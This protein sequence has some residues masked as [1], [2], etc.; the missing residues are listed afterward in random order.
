ML[1][2][3]CS[4]MCSKQRDICFLS[5]HSR[6]SH[7]HP[8]P[9]FHRPL[10]YYSTTVTRRLHDGYTT[11]TRPLHNLDLAVPCVFHVVFQTKRYYGSIC[12]LSINSCTVHTHTLPGCFVLDSHTTVTRPLHNRALCCSVRVPCRVPNRT[13]LHVREYMLSFDQL[14]HGTHTSV[15]RLLRSRQPYDRYTTVA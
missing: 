8:L 9:D 14:L 6:S 15:T 11:V 10:K 1:F 5:I 4:M 7:T 3:R 12:F 13:T 2:R